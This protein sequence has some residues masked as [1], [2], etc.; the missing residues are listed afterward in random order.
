MRKT[1]KPP[2]TILVTVK[3]AKDTIE[4]CVTSLLEQNY[5]NYKI[6][7]TDAY[8]NDG[9]WEILQALA[10]KHEKI[11]VMQ[12]AGTAPHAHNY[13]FK[14]ITTDF[15]AFTDSDCIVERNWLSKLIGRFTSEDIVAT[16]GICKTP[17]DVNPLQ[18]LIGI[19]LEN[20]FKKFPE[21][22]SRLPTM[23]LCVR[24]KIAKKIRFDER[25]DVAFETDFG[26][27]LNK[28]GKIAYEPGAVIWHYH[29]P[30][31][32]SFFN[33]AYKY[34]KF[35][36]PVYLK[37]PNKSLGDH[38][39]TPNIVRQVFLFSLGL[40]LLFLSWDYRFLIFYSSATF[41]LLLVTYLVEAIQISKKS[42]DY[43]PF[44]ALF[45]VRNVAWVLGIIVGLF[46]LLAGRKK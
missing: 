32:R 4:E 23:S 9:T 10:K 41:L 36:I 21:Y 8:S 44:L 13:A 2:V 18:R 37:N 5:P 34:G 26:Y 15:I 20:R 29:R 11:K 40:L 30:S 19:E 27:R 3:N 39:S 25:L 28:Y 38:I 17:K 12:I 14:K 43:L 1:K 22:V 31:W 46:N 16:G 35:V 33:Q 6:F 24:T 7:I 45:S 42:K